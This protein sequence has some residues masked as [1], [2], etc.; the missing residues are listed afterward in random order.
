MVAVTL[1]ELQAL[2]AQGESSSLEFKTTTGQ[3]SDGAKTLAAMLNG[4][5]GRVLFGVT[6]DGEV[7]GQQVADRTLEQLATEL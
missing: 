7:R 5:G 3:R 2:V 4:F 1:A 6:P